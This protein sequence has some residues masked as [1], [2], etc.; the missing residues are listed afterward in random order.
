MFVGELTQ[1]AFNKYFSVQD[2]SFFHF[3]PELCLTLS[4][5]ALILT[6]LFLK[7]EKTS[8]LIPVSLGM[9]VFT[10]FAT[11]IGNEIANSETYRMFSTLL[12]S[13]PVAADKTLYPSSGLIA[14]DGLAYLMKFILIAA[15]M[16]VIIMIWLER[17][18][19]GKRLGEF[20][21]LMF[22]AVLGMFIMSSATNLVLIFVGVEISSLC[23]YLLVGYVRPN[24]IASEGAFKFFVYGSVSSAI[25][26]FGMSL[27]YGVTG[28]LYLHE[29]VAN[30]SAN[31]GIMI[32]AGLLIMFGF[33]YKISAFPMHFW[34]PDAYESASI[35][36]TSFLSVA[37]KVAGFALLI[38]F[39]GTVGVSGTSIS[40]AFA[41]VDWV[42]ILGIIAILTMFIGNLGAM[43]QNDLKRL[44]AF[45][46]IAHAG[47]ILVGVCGALVIVDAGSSTDAA[48]AYGA[49]SFYFWIYLF[50]NLGAFGIVLI[51]ANKLG[52][53]NIIGF[54]DIGYR[55]PTVGIAMIIILLSLIGVPPTGG[56]VG[57][58]WLFGNCV[59]AANLTS[60]S[61]STFMIVL[62]L[63]AL[64]NSVISVYYY[65]RIVK[66]MYF[67]GHESDT[68][69]SLD[70][71][72]IVLICVTV[73]PVLILG[74]SD[75]W[76]EL[77]GLEQ[78]LLR[79][80][81]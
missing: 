35:P 40:G 3:L 80:L 1:E 39:V 25:M 29:I 79:I 54:R 32:L 27:A 14:V 58:F 59:Q 4:I 53:S 12:E 24:K 61:T 56:F 38:R 16:I 42:L 72:S 77:L 10:A 5:I 44:F 36:V 9:L 19:E 67:A 8:W 13:K 57:K 70:A 68:S 48:N 28:S 26:L 78:T 65:F 23:S 46:S 18:L 74:L 50:T 20:L 37:S 17:E 45:S 6:D 2:G 47:Y 7:K 51:V 75:I 21:A 31:P 60:G 62:V 69:I 55:M 33:A 49:V 66:M 52:T 64:L 71:V 41:Q 22:G 15:S 81:A 76:G 43:W 11:F 34:A 73:I 63:F 30:S